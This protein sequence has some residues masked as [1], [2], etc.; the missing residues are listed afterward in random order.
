MVKSESCIRN[1]KFAINYSFMLSAC[2]AIAIILAYTQ[3][4]LKFNG[5]AKSQLIT[6]SVTVEQSRS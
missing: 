3:M 4:I 5:E 2:M 6:Q 1:K